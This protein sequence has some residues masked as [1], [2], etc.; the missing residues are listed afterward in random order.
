[1]LTWWRF[2][3]S[4]SL[5]VVDFENRKKAEDKFYEEATIW[6][7]DHDDCQVQEFEGELFL[8]DEEG[9]EIMTMTKEYR[10]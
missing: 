1:M 10:V 6:M 2:K 9:V 3:D 7:G 8:L 4:L 5:E